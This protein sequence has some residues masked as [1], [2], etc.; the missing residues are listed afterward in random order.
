MGKVDMGKCVG[1]LSQNS[2]ETQGTHAHAHTFFMRQ[3]SQFYLLVKNQTHIHQ[4]E[5]SCRLTA[6][7]LFWGIYTSVTFSEFVQKTSIKTQRTKELFKQE[8][9]KP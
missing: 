7:K 5:K 6:K 1:N 4:M 3:F 2:G 8:T 9:K